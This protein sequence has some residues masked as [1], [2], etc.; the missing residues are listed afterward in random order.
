MKTLPSLLIIVGFLAFSN[1]Q[2]NQT[3]NPVAPDNF[4]PP[5]ERATVPGRFQLFSAMVSESDG[6]APTPTVFRIDSATGQVWI[7]E[8]ATYDLTQY[9]GPSKVLIEGWSPIPESY[10]NN[11]AYYLRPWKAT[12]SSPLGLPSAK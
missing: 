7:Y 9:G 1:A 6:T 3:Y 11:L 2:T 4:P 8:R 12:N 10:A 5:Q